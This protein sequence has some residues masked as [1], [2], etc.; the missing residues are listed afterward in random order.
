M[1]LN[2]PKKLLKSL[3]VST[4]QLHSHLFDTR[5]GAG[6]TSMRTRVQKQSVDVLHPALPLSNWLVQL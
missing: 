3:T 4:C 1:V 2:F 5:S 6:L